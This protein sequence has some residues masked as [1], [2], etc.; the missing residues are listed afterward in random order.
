MV[1]DFCCLCIGWQVHRQQKRNSF[2][3]VV[4]QRDMTAGGGESFRESFEAKE[5]GLGVTGVDAQAGC[6]LMYH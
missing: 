4:R 3:G 2:S 5:W 1:L 6:L